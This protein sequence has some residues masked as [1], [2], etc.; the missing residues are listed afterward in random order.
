ML[1]ITRAVTRDSEFATSLPAA[2]PGAGMAPN[3]LPMAEC[4]PMRRFAASHTFVIT[5]AVFLAII[6][7]GTTTFGADTTHCGVCG[8]IFGPAVYT[9]TDKVTHE[10]VFLCYECAA[11]P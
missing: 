5:F 8:K 11:W 2:R 3:V 7:C 9:L 10:K 6:L 1:R 4:R